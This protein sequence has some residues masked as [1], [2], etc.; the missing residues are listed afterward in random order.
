MLVETR[1][2]SQVA[3][4][5]AGGGGVGS[6]NA[7]VVDWEEVWPQQARSPPWL[8][9]GEPC[10][11]PCAAR[12]QRRDGEGEAGLATSLG[13]KP[14]I[15]QEG[16]RFSAVYLCLGSCTKKILWS[17]KAWFPW[18]PE[19]QEAVSLSDIGTSLGCFLSN[20]QPRGKKTQMM[21]SSVALCPFLWGTWGL[22]DSFLC[23]PPGLQPRASKGRRIL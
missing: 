9:P 22:A 13:S 1:L 18:E 5:L 23:L 17:T 12:C 10:A 7:A 21:H 6:N 8:K 19:G 20:P 14:Y 3:S 11:P 2:Y 15:F 16:I 4:D